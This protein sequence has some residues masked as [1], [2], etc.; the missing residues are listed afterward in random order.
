MTKSELVEQLSDVNSGLNK[1]EAELIVNTI[2]G[3]IGDAL[4]DGDRV[5]I[6]GFGSFSIRERDAREARNPKSG[7]VVRIPSKKTPFFKTGKE[8]RA[9]VD[10]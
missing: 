10:S 4:A 8:L 7:E 9:R 1:K 2:F 5:E 3:S 6:R